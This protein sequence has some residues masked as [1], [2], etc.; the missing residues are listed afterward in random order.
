MDCNDSVII[1][2]RI[3]LP[4][5]FSSQMPVMLPIVIPRASAKSNSS[6]IWFL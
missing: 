6:N 1:F 2:D 3:Y 5:G 4:C